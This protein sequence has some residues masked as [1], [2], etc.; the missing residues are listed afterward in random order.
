MFLYLLWDIGSWRL[1]V[2]IKHNPDAENVEFG[3]RRWVTFGFF[4]AVTIFTL[5]VH[6]LEIQTANGVVYTN[7]ILCGLLLLYRVTKQAFR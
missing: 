4:I 1:S 5:G 7:W 6:F 3:G 2:S